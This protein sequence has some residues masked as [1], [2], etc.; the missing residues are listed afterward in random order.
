[1]RTGGAEHGSQLSRSPDNARRAPADLLEVYARDGH[2]YHTI[3]LKSGVVTQGTFDLAPHLGHYSFPDRMDGM[4]VL[5]VGTSDGFFAFE[6]ES[7]GARVTAIDTDEYDGTIGHSDIA[8]PFV[9]SYEKKYSI[10]KPMQERFAELARSLD[11]PNVNRRRIAAAVKG[12]Q[13]DFKTRSIYDLQDSGET[14]DLVFCGDLIEH[15]KHPVL[16]AENLRSA[17]RR[18]CIVSLSN[19]LPAGKRGSRTRRVIRGAIRRLGLSAY[20]VEASEA[21]TYKGNV[22]GGAFFFFHPFAF[23]DVLISAGFQHVQ[24][25]GEFS[26]PHRRTGVPVRRAVFHCGV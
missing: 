23:K 12:S 17:T 15:L 18:K 4:T 7:R 20:L 6:F 22:S 16:A 13:V 5:D 9:Q 19:A 25:V 14:Y 24:L 10:N 26:A 2:W 3:E 21:A 1:M 8:V 11:L